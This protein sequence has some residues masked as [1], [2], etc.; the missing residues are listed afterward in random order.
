MTLP[1]DTDDLIQLEHLLERLAHELHLVRQL[2]LGIEEALGQA[3]GDAGRDGPRRTLQDFDLL[4][5]SAE[6][7]ESVAQALAASCHGA[8][9][10]AAS[11]ILD[12]VRLGAM[13]DR[14]RGIAPQSR[15]EPGH[16]ETF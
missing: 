16:V 9:M 15:P 1:K 4:L 11:R 6:A 13:H 5:Q 3:A 14:L 2:G 7:L 8:E 12:G 10:V